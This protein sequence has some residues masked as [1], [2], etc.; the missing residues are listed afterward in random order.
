MKLDNLNKKFKQ[1][2]LEHMKFQSKNL[3]NVLEENAIGRQSHHYR[4]AVAPESRL[5]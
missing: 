5:G 3:E 2:K 1:Q 4:R